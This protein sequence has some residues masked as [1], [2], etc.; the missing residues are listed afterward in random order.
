[1]RLKH[2]PEHPE[3]SCVTHRCLSIGHEV[4][5]DGA[6]VHGVD[7][8]QLVHDEVLGVGAATLV[9]DGDFHICLHTKQLGQVAFFFLLLE[10]AP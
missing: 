10:V 3:T 8:Q 4:H 1:M 2:L 5:V 9:V 7:R 6:F